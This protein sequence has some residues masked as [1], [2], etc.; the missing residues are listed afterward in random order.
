MEYTWENFFL[1]R[2]RMFSF[3]PKHMGEKSLSRLWFLVCEDMDKYKQ[4][5]DFE[6]SVLSMV[7]SKYRN[8]DDINKEYEERIKCQ[9]RY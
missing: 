1:A 9:A 8:E 2:D 3:F 7:L 5:L 4:P 6:E